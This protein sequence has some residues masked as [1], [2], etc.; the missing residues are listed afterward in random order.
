MSE[1]SRR[2]HPTPPFRRSELSA[3]SSLEAPAHAARKPINPPAMSSSHEGGD[4]ITLNVG[5]QE[6]ATTVATLCKVKRREEN[7]SRGASRASSRR[8]WKPCPPAWPRAGP[9]GGRWRGPGG[10]PDRFALPPHSHCPPVSS[11]SPR[12]LSLSLSV[13]SSGPHLH[14]GPHVRG[15][16]AQPAGR[17]GVRQR[18]GCVGVARR[19]FFRRAAVSGR[20][21][22]FAFHPRTGPGPTFPL[23]FQRPMAS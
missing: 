12:P 10:A 2:R 13:S 14:A 9:G 7:E 22:V 19:F 11:P 18:G 6:F 16:P 8:P 5:G 4:I 3:L 17:Q 1:A 15:R 20:L 21:R 23:F